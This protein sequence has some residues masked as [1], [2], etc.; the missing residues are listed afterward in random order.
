MK[1]DIFPILH[2]YISQKYHYILT[3][4]DFDLI[5]DRMHVYIDTFSHPNNGSVIC[6]QPYKGWDNNATRVIL[7][8][9]QEKI[10]QYF[11]S[12]FIKSFKKLPPIW[13]TPKIILL[14]NCWTHN[15][16]FIKILWFVVFYFIEPFLLT[17]RW[18][19]VIFI[20]RHEQTLKIR[21]L[22]WLGFTD[23]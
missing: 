19:I 6:F 2:E 9:L 1:W 4:C 13:R 12:C 21:N 22:L 17:V 7:L 8:D 23:F 3:D 5:F 20:F 11:I 18:V 10:L 14:I 15:K 16:D